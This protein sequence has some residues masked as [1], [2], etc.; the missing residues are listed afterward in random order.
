MRRRCDFARS[1]AADLGYADRVDVRCARAE[2]LGR[3][4]ALREQ[5]PVV[6][7]RSFGPAAVTAELA[8]SFVAV[9]GWVVVSEP[10]E[11]DTARWDPGGLAEL[12]LGPAERERVAGVGMAV[13]AKREALSER[14]PR[15]TGVPKKR[16]LW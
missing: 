14:F 12:G 3:E 13:I 1:A 4:P 5:F 9:G 7:A 10:P 6:V 16:P 8:A 11:E 2:V 15:R